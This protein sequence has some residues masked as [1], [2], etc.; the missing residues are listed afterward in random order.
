MT[1]ETFNDMGDSQE[2]GFTQET[3]IQNQDSQ[4]P[5]EKS[6][7]ESRVNE[8]IHERTKAASQKAYERAKA[9]LSAEAE[10]NRSSATN[11]GGMPQLSEENLRQMMADEFD[12]RQSQQHEEIQRQH[13]QKQIT[14]LANEYMGKIEA[15]RDLYP[16]LEKR[17]EEIG[18]FASLVPFI[19]ETD[20]VAGLTDHLLN[21]GNVVASLLVLN[22]VSPVFLRRELK[23]I[24]ASIKNND[25]ART[26]EY[27]NEPLS[28]PTPSNNT[29]DSG[30]GSIEA[31]KKQA[32]LRG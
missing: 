9:E 8:L 1:E 19:N 10:K 30:S 22:Q 20:E 17:R 18:E 26:R 29:M 4:A 7:S 2:Q 31:L 21:N 6:F 14:D 12:K 16:D 3:N 13:T 28:Q 11:M 15:A 5:K 25:V 32:Y 24:A 27:P 23:K